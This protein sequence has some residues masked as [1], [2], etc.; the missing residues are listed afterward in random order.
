MTWWPGWNSI[1]G[2]AA[3]GHFWFWFGI[4]C[5][6]LLAASEIA[7]YRYGLRKDEL[8][9]A[10]EQEK[11]ARHGRELQELHAKLSDAGARTISPQNH[12]LLVQLLTPI[13]IK[14]DMIFFNPLMT[15]GEAV[16]F[17]D[18]IKA[19]L[20]DAGFPVEDVPFGE[21]L[22]SFN[23]LGVFFFFKDQAHIP[24]MA[25]FI[26]EAFKRVGIRIVG[27]PEP[28]LTDPDKLVITVGGHQ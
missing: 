11:D 27:I 9:A 4:M 10:A 15:D 19:V 28:A 23:R 6:L 5:L 24:K 14:K 7:A 12:A 1:E 21:R 17:S 26:Y 20:S 2:T 16:A 22:M 3:W 8:V 13:P 25:N 18:Q